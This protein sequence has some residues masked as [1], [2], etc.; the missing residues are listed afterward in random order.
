MH[1]SCRNSNARI[2][3]FH[4]RQTQ[5]NHRP[6]AQ[7]KKR[8]KRDASM[9]FVREWEG[10]RNTESDKFVS[11]NEA[12]KHH[13][14]RIHNMNNSI[15]A[16]AAVT[17][18]NKQWL[19][20]LR[21]IKRGM[22]TSADITASKFHC[23]ECSFSLFCVT[24]SGTLHSTFFYIIGENRTAQFSFTIIAILKAQLKA[25]ANVTNRK[26]MKFFSLAWTTF[27]FQSTRHKQALGNA[28]ENFRDNFSFS[29]RGA[30]SGL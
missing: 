29:A 22:I 18:R 11:C 4:L 7:S 9:E 12:M 14:I 10:E 30:I 26:T 16:A 2:F 27:P 6:K 1:V 13:T 20:G 21:S 24:A 5:K 28:P 17:R 23:K 15:Q 8:L 25:T 3:S 19:M